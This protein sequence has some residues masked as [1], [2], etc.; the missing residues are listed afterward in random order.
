MVQFMSESILQRGAP[1]SAP[2]L[3]PVPGER[4]KGARMVDVAGM[5]RQASTPVKIQQLLRSGKKQIQLLSRD[6]IDEIISRSIRSIVEKY[7]AT[8]TLAD[9]VSQRRMEAESKEQ[10]DD[11]LSQ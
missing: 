11:L 5:I 3:R 10:F 1:G 7:R 9:P 2:R 4:P 8:G 6:K